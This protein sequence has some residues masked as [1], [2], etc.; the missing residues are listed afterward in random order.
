MKSIN[1]FEKTLVP[2]PALGNYL[3]S[4]CERIARA[5]VKGLSLTLPRNLTLQ[6]RDRAALR[7]LEDPPFLD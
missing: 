2:H 7:P 4:L 6:Q 1:K 5:R 3:L